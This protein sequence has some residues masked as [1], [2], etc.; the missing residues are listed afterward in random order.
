MKE[1]ILKWA[2]KILGIDYQSLLVAIELF[3]KFVEIFGS[4][5]VAKNYCVKLNQKLGKVKQEEAK[6]VLE[7][8]A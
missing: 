7:K 2:A 4:R 5:S 3:K 1:M 6:R 8:I